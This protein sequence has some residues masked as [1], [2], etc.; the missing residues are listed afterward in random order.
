MNYYNGKN[1][2]I[3]KMISSNLGLILALDIFIKNE[4]Q[5]NYKKRKKE[6]KILNKLF[7]S[8][9]YNTAYFMLS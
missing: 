5:N 1:M 2:Y 9:A 4:Y 7:L 6:N 3:L 8:H